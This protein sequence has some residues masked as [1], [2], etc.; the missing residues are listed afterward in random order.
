M[1]ARDAARF[2]WHTLRTGQRFA[3]IDEMRALAAEL[4]AAD[5]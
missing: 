3:G 4:R 5:P 1:S 2:L